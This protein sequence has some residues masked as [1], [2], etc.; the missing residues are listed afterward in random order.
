VSK[1]LTGNGTPIDPSLAPLSLWGVVGTI[2]VGMSKAVGLLVAATAL[3]VSSL[4]SPGAAQAATFHVVGTGGAG[5]CQRTSPTTSAPTSG[6]IG[7]R[8]AVT[9]D[10]WV[11]GQTVS[12]R[13]HGR[14]IASRRWARTPDGHYVAA[15]F[16]NATK[17]AYPKCTTAPRPTVPTSTTPT[18]QAPSGSANARAIA[19]VAERAPD[20][21]WGDWCKVFVNTTVRAAIGR[22]LGGY[23]Q[24][25]ATAGAR[26][27]TP[28]QA[29]R[30]D[31]VQVTPPGST[32]DTAER[33]WAKKQGKLHA[34]V[35]LA[36]LGGGNL[37][38]IDSNWTGA[39]TVLRHR[40]NPYTWAPGN[41]I[42]IWRF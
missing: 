36:N 3:G 13:R 31:I 17:H 40:L 21:T 41:D 42:R 33:L 15:L 11:L 14:R 35:I 23:Q 7:P 1:Q 26:L 10:C 34:M 38:V 28:A 18:T 30:G 16:L 29:A 37:S 9:V 4:V 12:D 24:G 27:V 19:D 2:G 22:S 39:K 32:D 20:G 6:C 8:S 5:V 25:Y